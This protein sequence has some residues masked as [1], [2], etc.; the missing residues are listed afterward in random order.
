V[1]GYVRAAATGADWE[2]RRALVNAMPWWISWFI[3]TPVIAFIVAR[4]PVDGPRR[5][6]SLGALAACGFMVCGVQLTATAS[7][8][9]WTTGRALGIPAIGNQIERY[10]GSFLLES[11]LTYV[12]V[13]GVL[14]AIDFARA[15]RD[16]RVMRAQAVAE[17]TKAQLAALTMEL[18]PHFLFNTMS[19]ISGL[20]GQDRATEAREVIRRL[21]DL[22]RRTLESG[23]ADHTT[24]AREV[25]FLEDYLYIQR[26]RFSDRLD[27]GIDVADDARD[28]AIP[29]MLLQPLVENAVRHGVEAHEGRGRVQVTVVRNNGSLRVVVGDSG[30]GFRVDHSGVLAREGVG[31]A[32]TRARLAHLYSADGRLELRNNPAGGAEAIVTIPARN[33]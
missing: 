29:P 3:L 16:E 8:Y 4:F 1:Q 7:I 26:V 17:T 11:L 31:I 32:N 24:V 21:S 25:E 23:H 20:V 6:R 18:N 15:A 10:A 14:I 19:A 13:A 30:R 28:C 5:R 9:W 12:A 27:V 2:L 33:G 22:L